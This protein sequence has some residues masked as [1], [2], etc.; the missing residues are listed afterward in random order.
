MSSPRLRLPF[1]AAALAACASAILLSPSAARA[2]IT[3]ATLST[4]NANYSGACPVTLTFTGTI[5]GSAGPFSFQFIR[6]GVSGPLQ[7]AIMPASGQLAVTD[8]IAVAANSSGYDQINVPNALAGRPL[9]SPQ[10]PYIVAC[11]QSPSP[12]PSPALQAVQPALHPCPTCIIHSYVLHPSN[13][14]TWG[15]QNG[16]GTNI[17]CQLP[18]YLQPGYL[19]RPSGSTIVG[20]S[21][22]YDASSC[23]LGAVLTDFWKVASLLQF[24]FS[25]HRVTHVYQAHLKADIAGTFMQPSARSAAECVN[26][27]HLLSTP[28]PTGTDHQLL[29]GG[30]PSGSTISTQSAAVFTSST[31]IDADVA[32]GFV[33]APFAPA[34]SALLP[35]AR[36]YVDD[37]HGASNSG[38]SDACLLFLTNWRLEIS[39]DN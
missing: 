10:A 37:P 24:D 22:T 6:N 31:G 13:V 11:A 26:A 12:T 34:G 8:T 39:A 27:V 5:T 35:P 17:F 7:N 30:A 29:S 36:L 32:K 2:A 4:V 15:H 38:R 25:G 20:F 33:Q 18:H 14:G 1:Y 19:P 28:W 23:G 9:R 3:Q 16:G 21:D